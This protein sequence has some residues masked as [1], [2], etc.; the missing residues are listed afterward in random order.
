MRLL[1]LLGYIVWLK[2]SSLTAG[3]KERRF[4]P[5]AQFFTTYKILQFLAVKRHAKRSFP[6]PGISSVFKMVFACLKIV[7]LVKLYTSQT[8][9]IGA[10]SKMAAYYSSSGFVV[11]IN[12]NMIALKRCCKWQTKWNSRSTMLC[13]CGRFTQVNDASWW[14]LK[15]WDNWRTNSC[16]W[17][18]AENE[19]K[20]ALLNCFDVVASLAQWQSTGPCK[21]GVE[22]SNPS[23]GCA[24]W[25]KSMVD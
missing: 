12:V 7:K 9:T 23:W 13:K 15:T 18:F 5:V 11:F 25:V 10:Y 4:L 19:C 20:T 16:L 24:L 17:R 6:V 3:T 8:L 22:G 2:V 1:L 21:P 14:D